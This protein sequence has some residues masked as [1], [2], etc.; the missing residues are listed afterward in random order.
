MI[1]VTNT[2]QKPRQSAFFLLKFSYRLN[3]NTTEIVLPPRMKIS[4]PQLIRDSITA[5]VDK[6]IQEA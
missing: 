5:Y 6:S 2:K 3:K 1:K 4:Q